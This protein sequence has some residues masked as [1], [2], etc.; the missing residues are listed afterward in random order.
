MRRILRAFLVT[1]VTAEDFKAGSRLYR[2]YHELMRDLADHHGLPLAAVTGAFAAL[3]PN[4]SIDGNLR[5]LVTVITAINEGWEEDRTPVSTYNRMRPAAFSIL[6]GKAEFADVC[7]GPKIAAF[8]HNILFP[9]TSHRVTID[10]HMIALMLGRDLGMKDAEMAKRAA[11]GYEAFERTFRAFA[12][13]H[14]THALPC[15]LQAVMW[16]ARRRIFGRGPSAWDPPP[17]D[18]IEPY[19]M[20][21]TA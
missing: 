10:G 6:R 17:V 9:L 11:G 5:S 16:Y 20:M 8:R 3:S 2:S 18:R 13:R 1:Q 12:E 4:S 7:R 14:C 15:D 19:P 21:E